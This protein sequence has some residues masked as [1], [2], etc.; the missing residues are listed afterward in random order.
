MTR[1]LKAAQGEV[2]QLAETEPQDGQCR[3][4]DSRLPLCPYRDKT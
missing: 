1:G 2:S 3:G 4:F